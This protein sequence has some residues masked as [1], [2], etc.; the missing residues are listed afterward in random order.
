MKTYKLKENQRIWGS[1]ISKGRLIAIVGT[2]TIIIASPVEPT[3]LL[4]DII[5]MI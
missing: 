5:L 1:D 2:E 3:S 4:Q